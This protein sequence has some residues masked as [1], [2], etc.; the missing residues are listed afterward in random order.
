[1]DS[2]Q[3]PRHTDYLRESIGGRG[4]FFY[5]TNSLWKESVGVNRNTSKIQPKQAIQTRLAGDGRA[6]A[7]L[8]ASLRTVNMAVRRSPSR[9]RI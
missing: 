7:L 5:A 6:Y 2:K 8:N 9:C 3:W 4:P 1:M